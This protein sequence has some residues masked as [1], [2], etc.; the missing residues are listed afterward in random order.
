MVLLSNYCIENQRIF[1][2]TCKDLGVR[3]WGLENPYSVRILNPLEIIGRSLTGS[4]SL[5]DMHILGKFGGNPDP[6]PGPGHFLGPS[7]PATGR[8]IPVDPA[9]GPVDPWLE[10]RVWCNP[11]L[12]RRLNTLSVAS[13]SDEVSSFRLFYDIICNM[14]FIIFTWYIYA[15]LFNYHAYYIVVDHRVPSVYAFIGPLNLTPYCLHSQ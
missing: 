15:V 12:N 11:D 3:G 10:P 6:L 13:G 2:G 8:P 9:Q 14:F 1:L 7:V 5:Q 4:A